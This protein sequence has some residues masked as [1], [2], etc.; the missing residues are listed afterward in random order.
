MRFIP[1]YTGNTVKMNIMENIQTVY[2]CVYREHFIFIKNSI[3]NVGLSLCIQGT[4]VMPVISNFM[5]RFI[6]VYTGNTLNTTSSPTLNSVYPC[7]YREHPLS[8]LSSEPL[9]GL[10]LCIQGTLWVVRNKIV[11]IRFIPV[12]TGNTKTTLLSIIL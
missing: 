11:L 12:Y 6:P 8:I 3:H 4:P 9:F 10:S 7:V 5:P 1:V 2:P